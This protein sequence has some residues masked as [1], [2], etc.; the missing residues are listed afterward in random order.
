MYKDILL[1]SVV[2]IN[3]ISREY[4]ADSE[5]STFVRR[6]AS[7]TV[8]AIYMK[9]R[10]IF[11]K[12]KK[13]SSIPKSIFSDLASVMSSAR[14]SVEERRS[15]KEKRTVNAEEFGI[16]R[17]HSTRKCSCIRRHS[18]FARPRLLA[19]VSKNE[20]LFFFTNKAI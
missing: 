18:R 4:F 2:S 20:I 14:D 12:G 8:A 10:C 1:L 5:T 6:K 13:D 16:S 11:S 19:A 17:I 15:V 7:L 3:S 9:I